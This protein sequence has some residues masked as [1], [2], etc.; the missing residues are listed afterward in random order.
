MDFAFSE[1]ALEYQR[2]LRAFMD[3]LVYPNEKRHDLEVLEGDRWQP[4][5]VIEELKPKA[6]AAELLEMVGLG[7]KKNAHPS[8]LSGGQKQ[9]VAIARALAG[10]LWPVESAVTSPFEAAAESQ[11]AAQVERAIAALPALPS[12]GCVSRPEPG[13]DL[14]L[15][16]LPIRAADRGARR[17]AHQ[18][19]ALDGGGD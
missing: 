18:P 7:A 3:E 13:R 15:R 6:R 10:D 5:P 1:R 16:H 17:T 4:V 14:T 9:R 11:T 19:P 8:D 2:R 12:A